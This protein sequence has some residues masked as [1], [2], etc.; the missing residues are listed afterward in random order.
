MLKINGAAEL[1]NQETQSSSPALP[2]DGSLDA[3]NYYSWARSVK[4]ALRIK[5]KLGFIDGSLCEPT[6]PND[7]LM[8]HWLRC[9]DVV[10][11]WMQNTMALDIKCSTTYAKTVHELWLELE[12]RF[13][14]Q[15]APRIFEIKQAVTMLMQNQDVVSVYFSK[16]KTLIDELL[17]YETIPSCSCGGLKI[18]VQ[19][20]Q[21]D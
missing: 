15:N 14:Q 21:R 18:V 19:N 17:N 16:L 13:A 7:L 6:D 12:Q 2:L 9:N 10:I 11:T 1:E 5:N 20:Q 8:E 3:S 4:R